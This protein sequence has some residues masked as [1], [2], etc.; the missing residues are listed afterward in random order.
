MEVLKDYPKEF[1]KLFRPSFN[2]LFKINMK[3]L[4]DDKGFV[5]K[6]WRY[7]YI[8]P[9]LMINY[10][11][12]I[13]NLAN[14]MSKGKIFEIAYLLPPCLVSTQAILKTIVLVPKTHLLTNIISELGTLWRARGLT[15]TQNNAK[16]LLL[17]RMN[18][19]NG[20]SYWVGIIGTTQYLSTPL[21]ETLVRQL[22]LKQD[23]ELLLPLDCSYPFNVTGWPVYIAV[24]GFQ[25]YSMTLCVS[26]YV[27]SE[28]IMITLCAL[29]GV[30]FTLLC[31][32]LLH[33]TTNNKGKRE[34]LGNGK[35]RMTLNDVVK[36]HQKLCVLSKKLEEAFNQ[37]IFVDLMFVGLTT[38]FFRYAAQYSRG[39]TY[40]ANN[41]VAVISSL[42]YVLY[43]CYYGE[44]LMGA[45]VR[46]GDMAYHSSWYRGDKRYQKTILIIILR[47]QTPCCLT[48]MKY[49][50]VTLNMFTKVMSSTWSYFSLMNTVY[51][52][53]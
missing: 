8:I 46:I 25:V 11:T 28:L 53:N 6:Y 1:A 45:S 52:D 21:V 48:S 12:Q 3:F 32:D 16:D 29:L 19:C 24:Y 15:E 2:Y 7:S 51:G 10:V 18:F 5:R 23:C 4:A 31:E 39:P 9:C 20:V 14:M 49:A 40:M 26:V 17:K 33:V 47:S 44:L 34:K 43:L 36:R 41:Y 42:V 13:W 50:P 38:C 30:E 37:M 22:V 27:G 35:E